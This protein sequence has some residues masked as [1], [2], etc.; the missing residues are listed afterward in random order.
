MRIVRADA[1]V[2]LC[3]RPVYKPFMLSNV[4]L[5]YSHRPLDFMSETYSSILEE[6]ITLE[7]ESMKDS[8]EPP[9]STVTAASTAFSQFQ[10]P[11]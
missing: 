5:N 2:E 8:T 11:L 1:C 9:S 3:V 10:H 7:P 4:C 6:S